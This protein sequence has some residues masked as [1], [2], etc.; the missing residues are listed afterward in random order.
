[1]IF[2]TSCAKRAEVIQGTYWCTNI[3]YNADG[4]R[5]VFIDNQVHSPWDKDDE[6]DAKMYFV[7]E[8]EHLK[9]N[10]FRAYMRN[11]KTNEIV[12]ERYY[13]FSDDRKKFSIIDT[14]TNEALLGVDCSYESDSQVIFED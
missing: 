14:V 13:V 8:L 9:G 5:Y 2:L 6:D 10:K 1:M 7:F 4:Q 3:G 11:D 12:Y